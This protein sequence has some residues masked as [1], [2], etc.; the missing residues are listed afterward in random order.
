MNKIFSWLIKAEKVVCGTGF[1]FLI[2]FVFLSAF[3]RFFR[4]SMSWNIDLAML[5][6]AWTAFLGADVAWR[7]GQ[8]IGVDILT[9][10]LPDKLRH[11]IEFLVYLIILVALTFMFIYSLR[12]A[13]TERV[14]RYQ[15]M[16]IPYSLVILSLAVA[17]LSMFFS[18]LQKIRR[19]VLQFA[20]KDVPSNQSNGSATDL[21]TPL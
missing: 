14:A 18:T 10:T 19:A 3:L 1:V 4:V 5:L 8:I 15:S 21:G 2:A 20:G 7:D 9:R 13:W 17:S 6:L 11:A 16:P 12:L